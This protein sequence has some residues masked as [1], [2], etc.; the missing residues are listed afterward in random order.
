[1]NVPAT[2]ARME[3]PALMQWL[4]IPVHVIQVG[5]ETTVKL[6][7]CIDHIKDALVSG[8]GNMCEITHC[9]NTLAI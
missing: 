9:K 2:L 3:A 4:R 5:V 7:S 6:V 1:M 8:G